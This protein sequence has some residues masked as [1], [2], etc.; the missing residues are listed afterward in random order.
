MAREDCE[1]VGVWENDVCPGVVV[2]DLLPNGDIVVDIF[3]HL[4]TNLLVNF[5]LNPAQDAQVRPLVESV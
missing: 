4:P 5:A 1:S 3:A 2:I